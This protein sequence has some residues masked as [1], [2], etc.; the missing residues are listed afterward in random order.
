MILL[1]FHLNTLIK[2]MNWSSLINYVI[3]ILLS[4]ETRG[5]KI[6]NGGK[7]TDN[8]SVDVGINSENQDFVTNGKNIVGPIVTYTGKFQHL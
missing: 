3:W 7:E 8:V 2:S 1:S 6:A 4:G 5:L